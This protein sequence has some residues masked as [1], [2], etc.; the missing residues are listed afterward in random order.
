[1]SGKKDCLIIRN[2]VDWVT[3]FTNWMGEGLKEELESRGL[4][5]VDLSGSD[6]TPENVEYW[7]N[8]SDRRI[9]KMIIDF[10]H[11]YPDKLVGQLNGD[12]ATI[13]NKKNVEDFTKDLHMY[14]FACSTNVQGGIGEFAAKKGCKSWLGYTDTIFWDPFLP[15]EFKKCV[16]SYPIAMAEGMPPEYCY[17]IL[18]N[19]YK[20]LG[21]S[22]MICRWNLSKLVLR[23]SRQYQ[24]GHPFEA[25]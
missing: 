2:R 20:K 13:I 25:H 8:S 14:T 24:Q 10:D 16:W 7:L 3:A 4:S 23:T 12:E 1:M 18:M 17:K 15:E 11:G 9:S 5:V 21:R 6:A 22:S 19:E